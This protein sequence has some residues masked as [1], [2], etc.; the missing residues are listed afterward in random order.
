MKIYKLLLLVLLFTGGLSCKKNF[1]TEQP[2]DFLSTSNA[3]KTEADFNASVN[4]LYGLVRHHYYTI[5]DFQPFYFLYRT[6]AFFDITVTT[7]NM[8][9]DLATRGFT[10][11]A[12]G[13]HYKIVSEANTIISRLPNSS[14]TDAQKTLFEARARFF[15]AFAYRAL[16]YLYGG[17]PLTLEE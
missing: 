3:F 4:N 7:P 11:F 16:A 2:L 17:A 10:N 5:N 1:L 9:A 6:D 15:R 12:W 8:A 14:L 13:A